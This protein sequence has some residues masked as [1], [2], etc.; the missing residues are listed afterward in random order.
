MSQDLFATLELLRKLND[1]ISVLS[2]IKATNLEEERQKWCDCVVKNLAY[3]P[4]F[5]YNPLKIIR[6]GDELNLL[7]S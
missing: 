6:Y 2:L 1:A 5:E 7:K 3:N 4:K